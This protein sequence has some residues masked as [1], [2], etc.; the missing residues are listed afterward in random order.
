MLLFCYRS[1]VIVP[2]LKNGK[3]AE[4]FKA[5]FYVFVCSFY[6]GMLKNAFL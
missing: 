2:Y 5:S 1:N 6:V 3:N 4:S